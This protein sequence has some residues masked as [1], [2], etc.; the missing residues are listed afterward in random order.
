MSQSEPKQPEGE[1]EE[2]EAVLHDTERSLLELKERYEQ[3]CQAKQR[4]T[5][6]QASLLEI[7]FQEN[8]PSPRLEKQLQNLQE[9]LQELSIIL[10]S[11]LLSDEENQGLLLAQVLFIEVFWQVVRFGGVGVILGWLLK[12]WA[13]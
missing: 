8:F 6:I 9:E 13:G 7:P 11:R 1:F 4:Q 2:F 3:I 5:E 10:E 12:T